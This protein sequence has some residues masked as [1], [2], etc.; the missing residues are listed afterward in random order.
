MNVTINS[1]KLGRTFTFSRPGGSYVFAD[2][3]GQPGTLGR[4]ICDGG[5][6]IGSTISYSGSDEA[7]FERI[8][9]R[10]YRAYLRNFF[11]Q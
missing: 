3:N 10:W 2:L 5:A 11:S 7:T 6:T 8:C 1:R 9:R 4:Q